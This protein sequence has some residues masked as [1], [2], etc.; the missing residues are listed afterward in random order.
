MPATLGAQ[1]LQQEQENDSELEDTI[2]E[3]NTSLK[4]HALSTD[5][6]SIY[7]DIFTVHVKLY[8]PASLQ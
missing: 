4:L 7:C 2:E 8:T 5:V 3:G 6:M 1:K